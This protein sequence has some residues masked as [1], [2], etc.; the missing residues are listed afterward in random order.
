MQNFKYLA[1]FGYCIGPFVSDL[2]GDPEDQF[3]CTLAH[4]LYC[5]SLIGLS[6]QKNRYCLNLMI[7]EK[8]INTCFGCF[9]ES[10]QQGFSNKYPPLMLSVENWQIVVVVFYPKLSLTGV[11]IVLGCMFACCGCKCLLT[12]IV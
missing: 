11:L 6:D 4:L 2:V 3:S 12:C 7:F 5:H 9:L 1:F 8:Y 10:K